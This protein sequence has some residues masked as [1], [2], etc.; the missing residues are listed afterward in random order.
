MFEVNFASPEFLHDGN[1]MSYELFAYNCKCKSL[2]LFS[3][4]NPRAG[5]ENFTLLTN[6]A[7]FES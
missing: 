2:D 5:Y 3:K 4:V 7:N 6:Y 1:G